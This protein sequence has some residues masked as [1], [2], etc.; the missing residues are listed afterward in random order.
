VPITATSTT[1]NPM[2]NRF[3]MAHYRKLMA[4]TQGGNGQPVEVAL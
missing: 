1:P 4:K 3:L 2:R